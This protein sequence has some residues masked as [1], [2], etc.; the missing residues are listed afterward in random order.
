MA[1]LAIGSHLTT[2]QAS[3]NH[4]RI[5]ESLSE[6]LCQISEHIIWCK[7]ELELFRT[8]DMLKLVAD[9]YAHIFLFISG[10]MDWM[11]EKRLKRMLDSFNENFARRFGDEIANIMQKTKRIRYLAEQISRAEVRSI[12]ETVEGLGRDIRLG[13]R[14]D[15]RDRAESAFLEEMIR[16]ELL[17]ARKERERI[18][19]EQQQLAFALKRM[20]QAGAASSIQ[21]RHLQ[22]QLLDVSEGRDVIQTSVGTLETVD[23]AYSISSD[24]SKVQWT[25]EE[26]ALNSRCLEDYFRRDRLQLSRYPSRAVMVSE[27][28]IMALSELTKSPSPAVLWLEGSYTEADDLENPVTALGWKFVDILALSRLPVM[29]YFCELQ[30]NE[31]LAPG[32]SPETQA[33]LRMVYALLRQMVELLLPRFDTSIDLSAGRFLRLSGTV[34]S[35]ADAL[36]VFRDLL[37]LIPE[38]TFCVIDGLDWLDDRS[39]DMYL[40]EFLATMRNS[41][42]LKVMFTTTGR[43][44]CLHEQV[45]TTETIQVDMPHPTGADWALDSHICDVKSL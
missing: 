39:T 41:S 16:K 43:S 21:E 29:S 28:T 12:R 20:L 14:G 31:Q 44:A 35:W 38:S 26:V 25:S 33:M 30:R 42:N 8:K 18:K 9:L 45:S 3:I 37:T 13:L 17:Q 19:L 10:T 7:A 5:A 34:D 4:E 27:E 22:L 23:P 11:M 2:S 36:S 1:T 32:N 6:A 24:G 15:A 40:T